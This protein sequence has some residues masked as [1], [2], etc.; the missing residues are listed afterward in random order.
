M[1][2]ILKMIIF[3]A[4]GIY[5]I[6]TLVNQQKILNLYA[7]SKQNLEEQIQLEK[8]Y[9][10]ELAIAKENINSSEYIE[11]IAR[12]ELSMYYPNETIYISQ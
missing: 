8:E 5:V 12:Q 11:N 3:I 1:K 10:E 2:K 6:A 4:I 9:S 7:N